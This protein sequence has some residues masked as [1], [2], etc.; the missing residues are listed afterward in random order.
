MSHLRKLVDSGVNEVVE[1][2]EC[3]RECYVNDLDK[4][5]CIYCKCEGLEAEIKRLKKIK[6][7]YGY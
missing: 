5:L 4:G 3:G 1:C 6:K 2:T 7:V